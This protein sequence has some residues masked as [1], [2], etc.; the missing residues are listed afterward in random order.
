[1]SPSSGQ[2]VSRAFDLPRSSDDLRREREMFE[3]LERRCGGVLGRFPQYMASVLLG[4]YNQR[5][6]LVESS[7]EHADNLVRYLEYCRENDLYLTFGFTDPPRDRRL[8]ADSLEYLHIT[9]RRADGI[10]V[11]GAKAV[12]TAAPYADE[13]LCLTAPR[14]GLEPEHILYFG[15]PLASPGLKIVCRESYTES[16]AADHALSSVFD[17]IDAWALFDD[18]FVPSDRIFFLN[19]VDLNESLFRQTPSAWGYWLGLIRLAVKAEALAG[20]GFAVTDYLGTRD[21]PR[22]QELLADM[23][24]HLES[25]RTFIRIAE[26]EPVFSKDGL[27]RPDPLQVQLGRVASLEQH[28]RILDGLRELCGSSLLMAPG[29]LDLAQSEVGPL[30]ARFLGGSD[31]RAAERFRMMKVAWEYT[32]GA[33][34]ARQLLFEQHNAGTLA[35]N[36]ARLLAIY[37][38]EPLVKLA[39]ELAG[40][41][42]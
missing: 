23:L 22:S 6:V 18:V 31:G 2:P 32:G 19:R 13:F 39:R 33:F 26:Q 7:P 9:E 36:K 28:P 25:L 8:A 14:P 16:C 40:S 37:D 24:L 41:G 11:R 21:N 30:L 34:A 3:L 17:E 4:L 10:V 20:I 5:D 29:A 15:I 42:S 27:A 12:A 35:T 38:P 1:M